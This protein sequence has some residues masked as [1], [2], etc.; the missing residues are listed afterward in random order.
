[1]CISGIFSDITPDS[2]RESRGLFDIVDGIKR[3]YNSAGSSY[4]SR[5]KQNSGLDNLAKVANSAKSK[6]A[7]LQDSTQSKFAEL[8]D[9]TQSK[10]AELQDR[11]QTGFANAADSLKTSLSRKSAASVTKNTN[12]VTKQ[13]GESSE[14]GQFGGYVTKIVS[15][16]KLIK[17]NMKN[18]LVGLHKSVKSSKPEKN[19][20]G[21]LQ[22]FFGQKASFDKQSSAVA[23]PAAPSFFN[24]LANKLSSNINRQFDDF[25]RVDNLRVSNI[26]LYVYGI[27]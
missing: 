9:R 14:S 11:T 5:F 20:K 16:F 10:L 6:F 27:G 1:M 13:A 19:V 7:E 26:I 8:Q 21:Y 4:F 24:I 25:S 18:A 23:S 15:G 12:L 2:S 3:D 22:G 17:G